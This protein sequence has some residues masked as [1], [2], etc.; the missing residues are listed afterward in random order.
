VKCCKH[1]FLSSTQTL[2]AHAA[3]NRSLLVLSCPVLSCP[4]LSCPVLSRLPPNSQ[5][6]PT[7]RGSAARVCPCRLVFQPAPL[8]FNLRAS[9]ESSLPRTTPSQPHQSYN[10]ISPLLSTLS[11]A[12]IFP[13]LPS[14]IAYQHITTSLCP[15]SHAPGLHH[16]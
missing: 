16:R 5:A 3:S 12:L 6:S 11:I 9:Q 10:Y 7:A 4:V 13:I 14:Y 15:H 1:L 8:L 2:A